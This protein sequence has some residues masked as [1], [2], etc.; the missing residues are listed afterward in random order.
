MILN[1]NKYASQ[2]QSQANLLSTQ[3]FLQKNKITINE[4]SQSHYTV[5]G[6]Q[7]YSP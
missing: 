1:I 2:K 6:V 4:V 3:K 5:E 7:A